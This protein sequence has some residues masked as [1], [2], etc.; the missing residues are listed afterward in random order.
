MESVV[1][2]PSHES[3]DQWTEGGI[4]GGWFLRCLPRVVGP[5]T[6]RQ[7]GAAGEADGFA[8]AQDFRWLVGVVAG[9]GDFDFAI[10]HV[11]V[12]FAVVAH[13]DGKGGAEVADV[14]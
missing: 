10:Q 5:E 14:G 12:G 11:E 2:A 8:L 13:F 3:K 1:V 9:G 4:L 6:D 7:H